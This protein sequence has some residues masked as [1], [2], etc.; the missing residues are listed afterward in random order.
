M[1]NSEK[2]EFSKVLFMFQEIPPKVEVTEAMIE[3]YFNALLDHELSSIKAAAYLL[4]KTAIYFPRPADFLNILNPPTS[5]SLEVEA[6]EAWPKMIAALHDRH[7]YPEEG[8]VLDLVI[9]QLG[10]PG[11]LGGMDT[12]DINFMR[13]DFIKAYIAQ[14]TVAKHTDLVKQIA[15]GAKNPKM[16]K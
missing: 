11:R 12:R 15:A 5:A 8:S 6:N 4:L 13:R 14:A 9:D 16:L 1:N 2:A 3:I 10:G 7:K